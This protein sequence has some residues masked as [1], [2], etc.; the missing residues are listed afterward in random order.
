MRREYQLRR[1][2]IAA[3]L[4]QIHGVVCP[5]PEGAFYA[6]PQFPDEWGSSETIANH[7]LE[8]SGVIVT[9]GSAYGTSSGNHLRLSFAT[10]MPIIEEGLLRLQNT[11]REKHR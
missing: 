9:P 3:G 2:V 11:L 5:E 4:N 10:S 1:D 7:L 6:F 8:E